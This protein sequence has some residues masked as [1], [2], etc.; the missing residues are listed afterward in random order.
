MPAVS[1]QWQLQPPAGLPAP[2]NAQGQ[3]LPMT[4]A[5]SVPA[6]SGALADVADAIDAARIQLNEMTTSWKAAVGKE[7]E[8]ALALKRSQE[9]D[10]R[11]APKAVSAGA[12]AGDEEEDEEEDEEDGDDQ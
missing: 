7:E 11:Q 4:S 5:L 6:A 8:R 3:T 1:V 12:E 10:A 9:G 2:L